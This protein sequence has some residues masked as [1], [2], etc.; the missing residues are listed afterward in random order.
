LQI[1]E[2]KNKEVLKEEMPH[3]FGRM[4]PKIEKMV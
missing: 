4:V 3:Y 2:D 1:I